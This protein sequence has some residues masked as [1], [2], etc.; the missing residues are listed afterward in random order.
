MFIP[1]LVLDQKTVATI[2]KGL[3]WQ[4]FG[5][6][7]YKRRDYSNIG[8]GN[9]F[10]STLTIANAL[11]FRTEEIENNGR[12]VSLVVILEQTPK[13]CT[14]DFFLKRYEKELDS[15]YKGVVNRIQNLVFPRKFSNPS[16]PAAAA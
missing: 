11:A 3:H 14:V 6:I 16:L 2:K 10:D 5:R 4:D 7:E 8:P 9:N 12:R 1:N 13:G 15:T